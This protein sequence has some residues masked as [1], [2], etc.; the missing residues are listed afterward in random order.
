[1]M[2]QCYIQKRDIYTECQVIIPSLKF[3]KL[4]VDVYWPGNAQS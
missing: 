2:M 1:M 4:P 3:I